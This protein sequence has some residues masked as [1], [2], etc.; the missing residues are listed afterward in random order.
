MVEL[1]RKIFMDTPKNERE[2]SSYRLPAIIPIVL[3]NGSD[4]W[5][6]KRSFKEYL[7]GCELFGDYVIDFNYFLLNVGTY[8]PDELSKISS[9][10]S[11]VFM[12]DKRDEKRLKQNLVKAMKIIYGLSADERIDFADWAR[13]VRLK[14][15][16]V[17]QRKLFNEILDKIEKG[18]EVSEVTYAIEQIFDD[19]MERGIEQGIERGI[20]RGIEQ[21]AIK[22]LKKNWSIGEIHE[23]TELPVDK[24]LY[25]KEELGV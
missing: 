7:K 8:D 5:T 1:L 20:E 11:A 16:S 19:I 22:M 13:D 23:Y 3:Y 9:L 15:V 25:L 21:T 10:I 24:I 6:A 18:K 4:T 14:R 12:S 2:S 17:K